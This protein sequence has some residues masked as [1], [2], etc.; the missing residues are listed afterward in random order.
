MTF[1]NHDNFE[2]KAQITSQQYSDI[3][4]KLQDLNAESV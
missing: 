3:E 1:Q 2:I 4:R